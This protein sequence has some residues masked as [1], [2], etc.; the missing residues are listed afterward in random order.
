MEEVTRILF[1]DHDE[2]AFQFRK[3]MAKVLGTLPQVELFH[4]AD[5][6][7]ALLLLEQLQPDVIVIDDE[8][9]EERDLFLDS[10]TAVHPPIIL[11]GDSGSD[12]GYRGQ[13]EVTVL[14]REETL[15]DIHHTLMVAA[16]VAFKIPAEAE[17][18]PI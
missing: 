18:L 16:S 10:L 2:T 13:R 7:E 11:Q 4:A 9:P 15:E 6:T 17:K 5:A 1:I 12:Q 3:C 14:Q 8:S